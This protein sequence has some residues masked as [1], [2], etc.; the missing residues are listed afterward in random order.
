MSAEKFN[1]FAFTGKMKV[2]HLSWM[3]FFITFMVWFNFAP[4]LQAIAAS[5]GLEK[6]EIKTL[7]IL[8]VA[9]TIPARVVI[10]M[11]TD[12]YGPRI[13]YSALLA[14]CAIPC[15]M[16]AL[17]DTFVQAA[18]A[19]F[20]LG[21]IGAGFVIGIRMVSEWFPANELGTAEGIYGGW[22]NFGSAAAAFTLPVIAIWFG[23]DDGWRYAIGLTGLM[24]LLFSVVYYKNVSDTPKGS[25]Y[26]KPK[27][28]GAMEVTSKGDFFFLLIMKVPMYAALALLTW[29]LSPSG[30]SMLSETASLFCYVG[31]VLL[32][33][34]EVSHVWKVNKDIFHTPVPEMHQYKFKQVAVLN[35][36][37][38]ATFGS[39]LAVVSM[40]PLFFA[41][42]FELTPVVA[43]MVASAYAFM[44]LMSRPGGGWLSDKFG[45]KP[46]LLILTAGLAVGYLLMS[47]VDSQWPLWLAVVAAMACSFFVQSG[48][49]AVFAVVPLIKR[50]LTGQIAGMTGAYGNVG[51]VTYLTVLS[52]VDY[53]TFFLVIAGT[54]VVGFIALLMM[55]EPKGHIAE[56]RE[57]GSVEMISVG[58]G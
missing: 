23:G 19:R 41:E 10:G 17:A 56:V 40:L 36:L 26:F 27:N 24:S 46:T 51:A 8:N 35:I 34:Y 45:R 12:R 50:R 6:S 13:V 44:N 49:G 55:E 57:D 29:K 43:G 16:F 31:L 58:H 3:A 53:S 48:E 11:L 15:F 38:F 39:E 37:Y 52:F 33:L 21:F 32:F 47:M 30:V 28:M 25:T 5:L 7:L 22:G 9:L 1:I 54:A 18:I 4:M 20:L 14:V 42:T 2:L